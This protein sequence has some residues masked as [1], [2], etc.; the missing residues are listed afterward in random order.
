MQDFNSQVLEGVTAPNIEA[1][2]ASLPGE[3]QQACGSPRFFAGDFDMPD[4]MNALPW[5]TYAVNK[6][7]SCKLE[8]IKG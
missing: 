1:N 3:V 2:L 6:A 8:T 4:V 7:N 5:L